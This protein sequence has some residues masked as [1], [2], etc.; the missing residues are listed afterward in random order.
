M[1]AHNF[2]VTIRSTPKQLQHPAELATAL[3]AGCVTKHTARE[4][5]HAMITAGGTVHTT[6]SS[7]VK[8]IVGF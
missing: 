8:P 5:P 3:S 2:A 7:W 1:R 6:A 4:Y